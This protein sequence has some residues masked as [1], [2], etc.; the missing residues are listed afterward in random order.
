M[1]RGWL[2][3]ALPGLLI[4]MLH[5]ASAQD[6]TQRKGFRVKISAP[7]SGEALLDEIT[8]KAEV[9]ARQESDVERVDFYLDDKLLFSDAEAPYQVVHDF[10][11]KA[12]AH[13]IKA[14]AVHREGLSVSDFVVSR[15]LDFAAVVDV[16]RVVLNVSVRDG[17]GAAVPGLTAADFELT[18]DATPQ[19]LLS[20][21]REERPI[22]VGILLDSSGSMRDR[23]KEAQTAAC[24]FVDTLTDKD[25]GFVIDFDEMV[26]LREPAGSDRALLCASIKAAQP[27]G[28]TALYDAVHAAYR[29]VRDAVSD[30]SA[31]VLLSDG[32]DTESTVTLDRI[33]DEARRNEVAVYAVGLGTGA[34]ATGRVALKRLADETGGR[35][36]FI[37]AAAELVDTYRKIADELRG[38][39]Q[40]VY[41]SKNQRQDGKFR[42]IGV[43]VKKEGEK[44]E[45]KHRSGYIASKP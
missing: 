35:A 4:G 27:V 30:R 23:M 9:T 13:V 45:I 10:G 44:F 15:A 40:L 22:L 21:S 12:L 14:V 2:A 20:V 16:Q 7:V 26:T 28:G 36:Y 25:R 33:V 17:R 24:A 19:T 32:D 11:E 34:T 29:V 38:L 5:S 31:L 6:L 3:L 39:Y 42:R 41:A 37:D 1:K 8:I 43:R 18:E